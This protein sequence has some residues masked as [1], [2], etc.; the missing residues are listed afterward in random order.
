MSCLDGGL[1]GGWWILIVV[2]L[3]LAFALEPPP[4]SEAGL[5]ATFVVVVV[6]W[7]KL[8]GA[9]IDGCERKCGQ[10]QSLKKGPNFNQPKRVCLNCLRKSQA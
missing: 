7:K 3:T 4:F 5:E 8:R 9:N 10:N 1:A 6:V 2:L